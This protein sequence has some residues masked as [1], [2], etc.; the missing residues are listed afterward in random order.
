MEIVL[1]FSHFSDS[2]LF[3]AATDS[4]IELPA[5][6][7]K[8]YP[9][10]RRNCNMQGNHTDH[11]V[12]TPNKASAPTK[13]LGFR[14]LYKGYNETHYYQIRKYQNEQPRH[15]SRQV[16]YQKGEDT[17]EGGFERSPIR[18]GVTPRRSRLGKV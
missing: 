13:G 18:K 2:R 4:L 6:Q 7:Q 1:V 5:T 14:G 9:R 3:V 11:Q 8:P 17:P 16:R 10:L 15:R 12:I